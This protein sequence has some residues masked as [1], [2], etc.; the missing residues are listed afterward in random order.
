MTPRHDAATRDDGTTTRHRDG[1][2]CQKR[3]PHETATRRDATNA[4]GI[5]GPGVPP[6]AVR[7]SVSARA[8]PAT[9][10]AILLFDYAAAFPSIDRGYIPQCLHAM[11]LPQGLQNA[12]QAMCGPNTNYVGR[13]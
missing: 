11:G 10:P 4:A 1:L 6:T 5:P 7:S 3:A 12:A 2:P 8:D 13:P 9:S